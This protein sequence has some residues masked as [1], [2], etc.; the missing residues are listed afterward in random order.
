MACPGPVR[1][2]FGALPSAKAAKAET[3]P[4]GRADKRE[5]GAANNALLRA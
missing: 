1:G 5:R 3:H 4:H 2:L